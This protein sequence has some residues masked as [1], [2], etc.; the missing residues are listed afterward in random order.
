MT[1]FKFQKTPGET[2]D[3][4]INWA[5]WLALTPD[6]TTDTIDTSTWAVPDG[7]TQESNAKTD[8]KTAIWLSGGTAGERYE[9]VNTVVT[10]GGRTAQ[11]RLHIVVVDTLPDP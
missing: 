4:A 1:T 9:V 2:L 6:D 8:T 7:L 3:Y 10:D 5:Q 11:R